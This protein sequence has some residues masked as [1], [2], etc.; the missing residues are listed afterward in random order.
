MKAIVYTNYGPP[1]VARL[2]EVA[3]PKPKDNEVLIKVCA[4]TVNRTDSGFRSAE[5]FISRFWSGLFRPKHQILGCEFAGIIEE[6][7]KGVTTFRK[8]DKVFG[9]NDKT[10]GGHA[11]YLTIAEH[12]AIAFLPN[13]LNYYE[14]APLTEG[15]HYALNNIKASRIEKGQ[16][17]MVYGATGAIGSAAV[18]LLKHFGT[19]VT[20][21]CNTK[22][23]ELVK[24]LGADVVID[25]Q[26]QDFTKTENKYQF[27]FDAVG[28]SSFGQ[29]KPLLT[30]KGIYISTELGK[31]TENIFLALTTPLWGGKKVLFP[32][33]TIKKEDVIFFKE[34]VERGEYKPVI[35]RY[36]TLEQIVEAYKYV[37]TG[38]KTGNVVLRIAE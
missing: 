19:K 2:M 25:Y 21:V 22:N 24:S 7:G 16:N 13:N 18:Q 1:E 30:E 34:L 12:D 4:S 35:D 23:V 6:T 9:Y 37:E 29:C 20:A 31:N 5:Y 27:I 8:G 26:T 15:A 33:P 3:N 11:E 17:A 38:Q 32:I 28:K 36:Y 14:A 10:C